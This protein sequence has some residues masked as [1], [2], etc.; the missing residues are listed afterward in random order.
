M[1]PKVA[2]LVVRHGHTLPR[3]LPAA[4]ESVEVS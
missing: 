1:A 2:L 4:R 3:S